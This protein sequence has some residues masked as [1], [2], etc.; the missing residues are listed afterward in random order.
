MFFKKQLCV[1][2]L[3][4]LKVIFIIPIYLSLIW[5]GT[6]L[7]SKSSNKNLILDKMKAVELIKKQYQFKSAS[8]ALMIYET[9][10]PP[11]TIIKPAF[12]P[13][14]KI[15][16]VQRSWLF[17]AD[18]Y[19]G[20]T[21]A[22]KVEIGIINYRNQ[23]KP[24]IISSEWW[25]IK[26]GNEKI[27]PLYLS[28]KKWKKISFEVNEILLKFTS[29]LFKLN[30]SNRDYLAKSNCSMASD[31]KLYGDPPIIKIIGSPNE[32]GK[33]WAII[34]CGYDEN[35]GNLTFRYDAEDMYST[36]IQYGVFANR[37]FYITPN[38]PL[39]ELNAYC[40]VFSIDSIKNC[41]ER[42][43]GEIDQ[44]DKLLLFIS[45]HGSDKKLN[46]VNS[47]GKEV[48]LCATLLNNLLN[49]IRC[50][51]QFVVINA[52]SSGSFIAPLMSVPD[53]N[54]NR[55]IITSSYGESFSDL[56]YNDC[57]LNS[58][59]RGSEFLSGFIE[60]FSNKNADK[61]ND[62]KISIN[63]AF[64]FAKEY[65]FCADNNA[66][67]SC[68]F[69]PLNLPCKQSTNEYTCKFLFWNEKKED[70]PKKESN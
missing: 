55:V 54:V 50:R 33:L 23:S 48:Y 18:F 13:D 11:Q 68:R 49:G 27:E 63:E 52:C 21:F 3:S 15:R 24:D 19:P 16:C 31:S 26:I 35:G 34:I 1:K 39:N 28:S 10:I 12:T 32:S 36:L 14:K 69:T 8:V 29:L 25:P 60:S 47:D 40:N 51:T 70:C 57:D 46:F 6:P 2:L 37:I 38:R 45:T 67:T 9:S 58:Y 61:D 4:V 7:H 41:F 64:E 30:F 53:T 5:Y 56:D 62:C 66:T 44:D 17:V 42:V 59:D 20:A 43:K 22:H 65:A